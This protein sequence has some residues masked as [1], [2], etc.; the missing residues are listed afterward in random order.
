MEWES[1][2]RGT[3]SHDYTDGWCG[4]VHRGK[5]RWEAYIEKGASRISSD[6]LLPSMAIA[7]EWCNVKFVEEQIKCHTS[8]SADQATCT[9]CGF[10][11]SPGRI[12]H[13]FT[14]AHPEKVKSQHQQNKVLNK[15]KGSLGLPVENACSFVL[16]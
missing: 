1:D 15:K 4:S 13:H 9:I 2:G 11:T 3:F 7:F 12:Y 14:T 16:F 10:S 5:S 6:R 8:T